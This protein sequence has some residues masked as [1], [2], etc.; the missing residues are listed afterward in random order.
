MTKSYKMPV[1]F[2]IFITI[3][4]CQKLRLMRMIYTG[5]IRSFYYTANN[6][7]DLAKDKST[8]D[9]RTWDKKTLYQRSLKTP[10]PLFA[11]VRKKVFLCV[12]RAMYW[13]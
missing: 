5:A 12:K 6:W 7:K 8:S 9:F 4:K 2:G 10:G 13:L 11:A 3:G 1:L